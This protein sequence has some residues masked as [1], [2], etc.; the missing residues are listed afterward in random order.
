MVSKT[1]TI[2]V[3]VR[4]ISVMYKIYTL[5][6][7]NHC[8]IISTNKSGAVILC[9]GRCRDSVLLLN[10][11]KCLPFHFAAQCCRLPLSGLAAC[12]ARLRAARSGIYQDLSAAAHRCRHRLRPHSQKDGTIHLHRHLL[13]CEDTP[14]GRLRGQAQ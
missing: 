7:W 10:C 14:A 5:F 13:G 6:L 4:G 8:R 3:N 1:A 12:G 2:A 9:S 11:E